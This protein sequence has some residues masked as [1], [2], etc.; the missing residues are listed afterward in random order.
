MDPAIRSTSFVTS[1][2]VRLHVLEGCPRGKGMATRAG[3]PT[4]AF[5]PGWSMPAEI[6]RAQLI[7]L[8]AAHCVAALDPRGQ[9]LSDVAAGGYTIE[10]RAEDV[11]EFVARYSR[12]VLVGW[13]LGALEALQYV[14]RHG[15]ARLDGLVLVDTSVG[16]DPAP[17]PG[18]DFVGAL[19]RDRRAAVEDFLRGSFRSQRAESE[20]AAL[21]DAAL[22]MPLEASLS[23]FPRSLPRSHWRGIV[24][25][26][27]KPMLY[28][29][30]AQFA[31][32]AQNLQRHRPETR[33]AVFD[34]A[35]HA[36]FVD[37][38]EKFNALLAKFVSETA[39]P[40]RAPRRN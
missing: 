5:V 18:D 33:V 29:V 28:A 1:D 12:V 20:I 6:W 19:K 23:L 35:G 21:T 4:V 2:G 36:L 13:S 15:T 7:E 10:R 39:G 27:P 26:F 25:S 30:S 8:G 38:A 11:G 34:D 32:Q 9:G 31:E 3:R 22:R 40:A 16:E 17:S 37:E 24:R 14:N